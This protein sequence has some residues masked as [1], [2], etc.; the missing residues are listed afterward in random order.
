M[1][2]L[3]YIGNTNVSSCDMDKVS[4]SSVLST[5]DSQH[6][7]R[8]EMNTAEGVSSSASYTLSYINS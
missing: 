7:V 6:R 8:T 4:V 3:V 2:V 1:Q 5:H